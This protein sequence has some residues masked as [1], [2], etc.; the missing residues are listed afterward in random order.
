MVGDKFTKVSYFQ[1]HAHEDAGTTVRAKCPVHISHIVFLHVYVYFMYVCMESFIPHLSSLSILT[2]VSADRSGA[3]E[4]KSIKKPTTCRMVCN[5]PGCKQEYRAKSYQKDHGY[6]VVSH[7]ADCRCQLLLPSERR[8]RSVYTKFRTP[9]V[10]EAVLATVPTRKGTS[11]VKQI[12]DNVQLHTGKLLTYQQ[13]RTIVKNPDASAM[14]GYFQAFL[15]ELQLLP[16]YLEG[17]QAQDDA[18]RYKLLV[19]DG[20]P[21]IGSV[22]AEAGSDQNLSSFHGLYVCLGTSTGERLITMCACLHANACMRVMHM[23][24]CLCPLAFQEASP[25]NNVSVDYTHLLGNQSVMN[26]GMY[27]YSSLNANEHVCNIAF[28]LSPANEVRAYLLFSFFLS[29]YLT[30]AF[31]SCCLSFLLTPFFLS[32]FLTY[33]FISFFLSIFLP[34]M[35]T[36]ICC[37]CQNKEGHHTMYQLNVD[38]GIRMDLVRCDGDKGM[39]GLPNQYGCSFHKFGNFRKRRK[40]NGKAVPAFIIGPS[41]GNGPHPGLALYQNACREMVTVGQNY[42]LDLLVEKHGDPSQE[43]VFRCYIYIFLCVHQHVYIHTRS[44]INLPM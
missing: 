1:A 29:I 34:F 41:N 24:V 39:E 9:A 20:A 22:L 31:F 40:L 13:A 28:M 15:R 11:Q 6:W 7:V 42:W 4:L 43:T 21:Q 19:K 30:H 8:K 12:I 16:D 2:C 25:V 33:E 35:R 27:V 37:C 14:T 32:F 18:A 36:P 44:H 23:S 5:K 10:V 26:G 17:L 38:A 3:R